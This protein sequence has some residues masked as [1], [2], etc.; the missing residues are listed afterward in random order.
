MTNEI[1]NRRVGGDP[2]YL[3]IN[4]GSEIN[5]KSGET[6]ALIPSPLDQET[7]IVSNPKFTYSKNPRKLDIGGL[8][9]TISRLFTDTR[10]IARLEEE[11]IQA[12]LDA[13][14]QKELADIDVYFSK[15]SD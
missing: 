8:L 5:I 11:F 3:I 15:L 7:N 4:V 1:V 9:V 6:N 12:S 13:G 14:M 2:R 10:F